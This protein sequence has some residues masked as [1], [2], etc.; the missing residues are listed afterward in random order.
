MYHEELWWVVRDLIELVQ[1][2]M[3]S[4]VHHR[5]IDPPEHQALRSRGAISGHQRQSVAIIS[6]LRRCTRNHTQ[7]Y[8]QS[9]SIIS[10]LARLSRS[11]PQRRA[12][13]ECEHSQSHSIM[14]ALAIT[15]NHTRNHTQ[16][17]SQS[18]SIILVIT[19]NH[20][21]NRTQLHSAIITAIL[22]RNSSPSFSVRTP[23]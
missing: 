19:L 12:S 4:R 23:T 2:A 6:D 20:A 16:S 5:E 21:R 18:H 15:L 22:L 9:H 13:T 1:G 10:K 14:L 7:S 17:Y 3:P 11:E 8:S